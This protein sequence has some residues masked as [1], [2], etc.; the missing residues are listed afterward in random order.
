MEAAITQTGNVL[1]DLIP[2]YYDDNRVIRVMGEDEEIESFKKLAELLP[3][4]RTWADASRG[5]YD[6]IV[7][8]GPAFAS[9]RAEGADRL[10]Q[11]AQVFPALQ[12]V[13]GD[14]VVG[15]LDIPFG[16]EIS[17]RMRKILPPGI[18]E[19]VDAE[20]QPQAPDPMQQAMMEFQARGAK[21]E[22]EGKEADTQI[23]QVQ[24]AQ[25]TGQIA[26]LIEQTVAL[27]VQAALA[28]LLGHPVQ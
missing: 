11:L 20:R 12:T 5:S 18:D 14:K 26:A 24:A 21:A 28:N 10:V 9:K 22:V 17:E 3:D 8:T 1:V 23:K 15:A 25:A 19:K 6:V 13:A 27:Q 2:H 16:K 7:T 4:G